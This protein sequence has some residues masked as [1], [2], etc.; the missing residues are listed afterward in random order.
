MPGL[1]M[2]SQAGYWGL[3]SPLTLT[4]P[5][6]SLLPV[7]LR[8]KAVSLF[9]AGSCAKQLGTLIWRRSTGVRILRLTLPEVSRPLCL[10]L[11]GCLQARKLSLH[12]SHRAG[13][14][15]C[16]HASA[17]NGASNTDG[18][19]GCHFLDVAPDEKRGSAVGGLAGPR[20]EPQNLNPTTASIA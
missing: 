19:V 18:S 8:E 12:R 16:P 3:H 15:R 7:G 14:N 11:L 6:Q 13:T 9:C 2:T 10:Y 20:R 4:Q 5:G 1:L 17:H